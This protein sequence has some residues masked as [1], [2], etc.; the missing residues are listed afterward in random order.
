MIRDASHSFHSVFG[1][2]S[3]ATLCV[4]GPGL[5]SVHDSIS[6]LFYET[7]N[8]FYFL[9]LLDSQAKLLTRNQ[10]ASITRKPTKIIFTRFTFTFLYG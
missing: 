2:V 4:Q 7:K 5:S 3:L 6:L 10:L 1:S 9:S 8:E